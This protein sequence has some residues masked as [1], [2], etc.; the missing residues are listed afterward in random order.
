MADEHQAE[1]KIVTLK[2]LELPPTDGLES[3]PRET[4]ESRL[5]LARYYQVMERLR[6]ATDDVGSEIMI[7]VQDREASL[8]QSELARAA[9]VD[10]SLDAGGQEVK[11]GTG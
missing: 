4:P 1:Q 6:Q 10:R 5:A 2:S 3:L 8:L 7:T 11:F 9:S